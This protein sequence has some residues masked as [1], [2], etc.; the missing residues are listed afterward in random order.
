MSAARDDAQLRGDPALEARL[1]AH[2]ETE[3][4]LRRELAELRDRLQTRTTAQERLAEMRLALSEELRKVREFVV[5]DG[6]QAAVESRAMVLAA[7]AEE[8]RAERDALRERRRARSKPSARATRCRRS[9]RACG[10]R[11]RRRR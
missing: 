4:R 8:L 1:A 2:E 10:R 6:R 3:A 5:E 7:E 9:S 11:R